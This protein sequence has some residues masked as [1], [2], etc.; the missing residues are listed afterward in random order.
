MGIVRSRGT[1]HS[2]KPDE[3]YSEIERLFEGPRCELFARQRRPGWDAWGLEIGKFSETTRVGVARL[4]KT[5]RDASE[6]LGPFKA[7]DGNRHAAGEASE[8]DGLEPIGVAPRV[9]REEDMSALETA[10]QARASV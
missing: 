7:G 8:L 4:H 3:L 6:R 2:R 1:E 9:Y 5:M 10:E